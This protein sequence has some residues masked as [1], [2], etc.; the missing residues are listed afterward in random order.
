M[1]HLEHM[2]LE[3]QMC[4]PLYALSRE[5]IKAYKPLLEPHGLTYTQYIAMLVLWEEETIRFKDLGKRL[6][7]DSG[8]LT[9]LI[10]NLEKSELVHK[11]RNPED[12]RT[13]TVELSEKG[14]ALKDRLQ[15]VPIQ[16]LDQF[17]GNKE[18]LVALKQLLDAM[19][20]H[21]EGGDIHDK[22][23]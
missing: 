7:L 2:K 18:D 16:I 23:V 4:F 22:K 9:P 19:L 14:Y 21:S 1:A 8:T 10:R 3:N 12:D 6:H 11:Y 5:V 15:H 13:V 20:A 17:D